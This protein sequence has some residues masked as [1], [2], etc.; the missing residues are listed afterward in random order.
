MRID[1]VIYATADLDDAA[2]RVEAQLGL[3]AMEGGRHEGH[4]TSNRIV[5]LGG[6]YLELVAVVD[7]DEAQQSIFGRAIQ[8][9]LARAGGGLLGWAVAVDDVDAVAARLGL[10]TSTISRKGLSARLAGLAE[11]MAEPFLPFFIAR[12]PGVPDPGAAGEAGGISWLEVAGDRQRITTWIMGA[13]LP[14]RI[15]TGAPPGVSAIGIGAREF[16]S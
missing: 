12:D 3:P 14:I 10:T 15:A 13:D 4:G 8:G 7:P 5:P 1:H 2:A 16:R 11:A 9:R 6:G